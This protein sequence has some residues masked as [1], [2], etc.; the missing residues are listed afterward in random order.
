MTV[1]HAGARQRLGPENR[2]DGCPASSAGMFVVRADGTARFDRHFHD[3]DEF[4]F[5]A[6]GCGTIT[7]DDVEHRV[8]PGDIIHTRPGVEHDIIAVALELRVFWLSGPLPPGSTGAH[9]HRVPTAAT[10]HP[11]PVVPL[12][13]TA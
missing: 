8:E 4:W 7:L 11:V 13:R 5:V 3:F 12:A 9:L 2:P 10:K 6:A 1:I